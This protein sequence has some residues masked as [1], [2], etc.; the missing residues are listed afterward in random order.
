MLMSQCKP[1]FSQH[2]KSCFW[3]RRQCEIPTCLKMKMKT[4]TCQNYSRTWQCDWANLNQK[5]AN[6]FKETANWSILGYCRV[7]IKKNI[8]FD[9]NGLEGV[10]TPFPELKLNW[11]YIIKWFCGTW[12]D[13]VFFILY[14]SF[15]IYV[16]TSFLVSGM[17]WRNASQVAW[18]R[19]GFLTVEVHLFRRNH[20]SLVTNRQIHLFVHPINSV[21][22]VN[23]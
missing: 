3:M 17:Q 19:P 14:L 22:E 18:H 21:L 4:G 9:C 12:I 5:V 20:S 1:A 13:S 16:K 15:C 10:R 2:M 6:C 23:Q 8:W 11:Q 7:A